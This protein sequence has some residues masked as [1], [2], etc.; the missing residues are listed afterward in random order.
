MFKKL[1]VVFSFLVSIS[2]VISCDNNPTIVKE[3]PPEIQF[4]NPDNWIVRIAI[5]KINNGSF[6]SMES[7]NGDGLSISKTIEQKSYVVAYST[8]N[9]HGV[10]S[11]WYITDNYYYFENNNSYTIIFKNYT[12]KVNGG[13]II[14]YE[15]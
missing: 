2:F 3:D 8:L 7:Y 1:L 14:I 10:W 12:G 5:G 15:D 9:M 11:L 6:I 4:Y 13:T